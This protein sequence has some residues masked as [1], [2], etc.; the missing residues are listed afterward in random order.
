MFQVAGVVD[1]PRIN[2]ALVVTAA[3]LAEG[4]SRRRLR[5]P[6]GRGL[7]AARLSTTD[8]SGGVFV[9]GSEL[10]HPSKAENSTCSVRGRRACNIYRVIGGRID[11]SR[12]G[13]EADVD[14]TAL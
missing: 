10:Q 13:F 7:P 2:T 6:R 4:I 11:T 14:Y 5:T 1:R 8:D 3:N 9:V 12:G